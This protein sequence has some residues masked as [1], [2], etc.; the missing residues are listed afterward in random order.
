MNEFISYWKINRGHMHNT[1]HREWGFTKTVCRKAR[2]FGLEVSHQLDDL[3]FKSE[4]AKDIQF[5]EEEL[6]RVKNTIY[7]DEIYNGKK[8]QANNLEIT[9][10]WFIISAHSGQRISDFM[11]FT[12]DE[13]AT[14]NTNN[15]KGNFLNFT[16]KKTGKTMVIPI[17]SQ[18]V[19]IL[20]KRNG[21]FPPK[22]PNQIYN[23][24]LKVVCKQAGI[25]EMTYGGLMI[26]GRK[27][28]GN[29][30]KYLLATSKNCGRRT[31]ATNYRSKLTTTELQK[32]T[33]HSTEKMLLTYINEGNDETAIRILEKLEKK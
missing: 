25:D 22:M 6:D 16:Q 21:E 23:Q 26:E 31:F 11:K 3:N 18:V 12:T 24:H 13:I 8:Y 9:K 4:E 17:L 5:S 20:N 29:Y 15:G 2:Y 33:G 28:M 27:V 10:D 19:E 1:T 32:F 30:K 14:K 7:I